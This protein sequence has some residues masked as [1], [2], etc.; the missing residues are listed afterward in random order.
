MTFHSISP[1][2]GL[3]RNNHI[4]KSEI[5]TCTTELFRDIYRLIQ[6]TNSP[7]VSS[8][9]TFLTPS[10]VLNKM[11]RVFIFRAAKK[12]PLH[13]DI[14]S[15]HFFNAVL[16]LALLHLA[17]D[18]RRI[19]ITTHADSST[20]QSLID[21]NGDYQNTKDPMSLDLGYPSSYHF[22]G[23]ILNEHLKPILI[24]GLSYGLLPPSRSSN[25]SFD[26]M[27][28]TPILF[29]AL[30]GLIKFGG[31][32]LCK[33][34]ARRLCGNS[35][36]EI[37][38]SVSPFSLQFVPSLWNFL[39]YKQKASIP[40]DLLLEFFKSLAS[41]PEKGMYINAGILPLATIVRSN[42][43]SGALFKSGDPFSFHISVLALEQLLTF[44]D[45]NGVQNFIRQLKSFHNISSSTYI[46]CPIEIE[47][48]ICECLVLTFRKKHQMSKS[49]T[50]CGVLTSRRDMLALYY[51]V[52]TVATLP[53]LIE[54]LIRE[55]CDLLL[56]RELIERVVTSRVPGWVQD[57]H[58]PW[59]EWFLLSS[60]SSQ[61]KFGSI[62]GETAFLTAFHQLLVY[63]L[64]PVMESN[65]VNTTTLPL[66]PRYLTSVGPWISLASKG[67]LGEKLTVSEIINAIPMILLDSFTDS[68]QHL[69]KVVLYSHASIHP[70]RE[71]LFPML[72][73]MALLEIR[74]L[75]QVSFYLSLL[76][77]RI[78][79]NSESV[80]AQPIRS[81]FH[82]TLSE[83]DTSLGLLI[84]V[85]ETIRLGNFKTTTPSSFE[86][87][88]PF[89][90]LSLD[91][92][93]CTIIRHL[94]YHQKWLR[95]I[96]IFRLLLRTYSHE[97]IDRF[98]SLKDMRSHCFA[99]FVATNSFDLMEF[100]FAAMSS[101]NCIS[102]IF[103]EGA[104]HSLRKTIDFRVFLSDDIV[105]SEYL[106][107]NKNLHHS[108]DYDAIVLA[109]SNVKSNGPI[110]MY[111]I[112]NLLLKN[113]GISPHLRRRLEIP[114]FWK[115]ARHEFM[116]KFRRPDFRTQLE[117]IFIC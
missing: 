72:V 16:V 110:R 59:L 49:S 38:S 90:F 30:F 64:S 79:A 83:Y 117:E 101:V 58:A 20:S 86:M 7:S 69:T 19:F 1:V 34:A 63:L 51:S 85:V 6:P 45:W 98:L 61:F 78:L 103:T 14:H 42:Y 31:A 80:V 93:Y 35:I 54:F 33:Y 8:G 22:I 71:I 108:T 9:M 70:T 29:W 13:P 65:T 82:H 113:E 2:R 52:M 102:K 24:H 55:G 95:V 27:F 76:A 115:E 99:A 41:C 43:D 107:R 44:E 74:S 17:P 67:L 25:T 114:K 56:L 4:A 26:A 68:Y 109:E 47:E 60:I 39:I 75:K 81:A 5:V 23:D 21:E 88:V 94:S 96:D 89:T 100:L 11:K 10:A 53:S 84:N 112:R 87:P 104:L 3:V 28:G 116:R 32:P 66:L 40:T 111:N 62:I 48:K 37:S 12:N 97:E 105:V 36:D 18:S 73:I 57:G 77:K 92:L 106:Q 46:P 50:F 91:L 15:Q